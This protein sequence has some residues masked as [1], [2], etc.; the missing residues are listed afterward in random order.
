MHKICE[1][2]TEEWAKEI[3]AHFNGPKWRLGLVLDGKAIYLRAGVDWQKNFLTA[4]TVLAYN[5]LMN[6]ISV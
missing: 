1:C 2:Q 3:V 6:Y 4:S 5:T